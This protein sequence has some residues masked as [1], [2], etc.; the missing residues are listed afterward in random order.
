[1]MPKLK[2]QYFGHPIGKDSDAGRDWG[3]EEKGTTGY[4]M[5]GWHHWLDGRESEWTPGVGDGQGGLACCS[6][7]GREES[8]MTEWLNWTELNWSNGISSGSGKVFAPNWCTQVIALGPTQTCTVL[9]LLTAFASLLPENPL[10][11]PSLLIQT[12]G[13]NSHSISPKKTS[14]T[15]ESTGSTPLLN[16]CNLVSL[17]F[18]HMAL[19]VFCPVLAATFPSV[20]S[21]FQLVC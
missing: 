16:S 8:D 17:H 13:F 5:A 6:P 10:L 19:V 12:S 21:S 4:E 18:A 14:Q 15:M 1:M 11:L 9:F 7:W 3:Q 2:L 20:C